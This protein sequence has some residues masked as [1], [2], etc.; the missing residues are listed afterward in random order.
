MDV[1][2]GLS[3]FDVTLMGRDDDTIATKKS[4]APKQQQQQL[5]TQNTLLSQAK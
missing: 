5:Q 4:L 2:I 3:L 1:V